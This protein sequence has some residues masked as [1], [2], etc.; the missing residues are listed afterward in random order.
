MPRQPRDR[1]R[2]RPAG[3]G[4]VPDPL[5]A[6]GQR[7]ARAPGPVE[8]GGIPR[9][10]RPRGSS[11]R[12]RRAAMR[13][14]TGSSCRCT[15]TRCRRR[16]PETAPT[17]E[18][19]RRGCRCSTSS[20]WTWCCAG[21]PLDA[22]GIDAADGLRQ[23]KVFTRPN[24][25]ALTPAPGVFGR[26]GADALQDATWSAMRDT[27]TGYG[28]AVFDVHPGEAPQP[29]TG[30]AVRFTHRIGVQSEPL[31]GRPVSDDRQGRSGLPAGLSGATGAP[32]A[33]RRCSRRR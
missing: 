24:R 4:L 25:P 20:R 7:R 2:Q 15:R 9:G 31:T 10:R 28:I 33:S 11:G 14:S 22:Y 32:S 3:P 8:S 27:A 21:T 29:P 23:A 18:P 13:R 30:L 19:G 5:H 17:W 26:A 6:A 12:W 16:P 1:V